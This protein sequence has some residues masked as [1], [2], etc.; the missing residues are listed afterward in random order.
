MTSDLTSR[1]QDLLN[2][3]PHWIKQFIEENDFTNQI[4]SWDIEKLLE[5]ASA[6][7]LSAPLENAPGWRFG[8]D[9]DTQ[10][11]ITQL[12][13]A[14]WNQ[15]KEKNIEASIL[16]PWHY[17]L[18]LL[19]YFGNDTSSQLFVGG[20]YD[21]NE[22]YF[23]S[24]ILAPGMTFL[25]IGANEGLYTLFGAKIVGSEGQVLSFEPSLREFQRLQKNLSLNCDITS[26]KLFQIALSNKAGIQ[27]LKIAN[28]EHSGQNTLG[29][30]VHEG[31][32]CSNTEMVSVQQ[33]DNLIEEMSVQRI[34]IIKIDVEGAEFLVFE[35]SRNVIERFHPLICFELLDSALQNQG[36]S[37]VSL[38]RYLRD[39]G[40]EI[41]SW[42]K[43][44]G[45]PIK[46]IQESLPD[47]NLI[48]AHPSKSWNMLGETDQ[49]HLNHAE[50]EKAQAVL[51]QT[52]DQLKFTQQGVVQLQS[53]M[54]QMSQLRDEL[55]NELQ[56]TKD[57]F[58]ET[59]VE[60]Q[61]NKEVKEQI[62][63]LL[64]SQRDQIVAMESSKFWQ[65]RNQWLALRK[66]LRL[67]G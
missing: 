57:R 7:A 18:T 13:K 32:T 12:R 4:C 9:W 63:A 17:D 58:E 36:S 44:T 47:G 26:V 59:K 38:L 65:L 28:S 39:L 41:F 42:G 10:D 45:L 66:R 50:L 31:V 30:F 22:F 53:Q 6:I 27:S 35:G 51:E 23:L 62:Q 56:F 49:A 8:I 3:Q 14:I 52:Q 19:L 64:E 33:L 21:P 61:Q 67:P 29:D 15:L 46:T 25:D 34:D 24:R 5:I 37:S 54:S 55:Q 43:F 48:A 40:Y 60:L 11:K 16:F 1:H 2:S 20:R